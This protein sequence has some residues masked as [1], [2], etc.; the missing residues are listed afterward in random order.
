MKKIVIDGQIG[1]WQYSK[2]F[3]RAMLKDSAKDE[4]EV[5][6]SSLGGSVDDA[7]DIHGQFA[8]HGNVT[9]L[10]TGFNA[11]S[12]TILSLGA[13]KVKMSEN[14]FYLIH[15]PMYSFDLWENMN[16]DDID[17]T[18]ADL[19]KQKND[20]GKITLVLARMYRDKTG[21][22][23][24][25]ILSLMKEEKWLNAEEAKKL[26]FVDEIV[27]PAQAINFLDDSNRMAMVAASGYPVPGRTAKSAEPV[28]KP[29]TLNEESLAK[30]IGAQL[31]KFLTPKNTMKK[32]FKLVNTALKVEKL[33]S[34]DD[35][36]YLNEGQFEAIETELGKIPAAEA[37][38]TA[39][40]TARTEAET[41]RDNAVTAQTAAVAAFDTLDATVATAT[42]PEAKL[43]AVKVLLAA[44][45][46]DKPAGATT[47][48][49]PKGEKSADGVD[50]ETLNNLPHMKAEY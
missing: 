8:S 14:A 18:I 5:N 40:E 15:K 2:Q 48:E 10:Y 21:M 6:V 43:A 35:G 39:A 28:T 34:T 16:E 37:A 27:K 47:T 11:S 38:R 23:I 29:E 17:E 44:K 30:K 24:Q 19:E 13:K 12:A 31:I 49:D 22:S 46:G 26:G 42:T 33:D 25:D 41:A 45:P 4:V 1:P 50:W 32:Q 9:I 20:L 3:V 7:I 36:I